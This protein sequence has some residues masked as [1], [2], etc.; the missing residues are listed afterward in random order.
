M[1]CVSQSSLAVLET[2]DTFAE[3]RLGRSQRRVV[4]AVVSFLLGGI[5][6]GR[7]ARLWAMGASVFGSSSFQAAMGYV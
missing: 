6:G 5:G 7:A 2:F 4:V 3:L 1:Q